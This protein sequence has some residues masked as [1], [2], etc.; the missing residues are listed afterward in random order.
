MGKRE[1]ILSA[2]EA[3]LEERGLYGLSMK[4]LAERAGIAAGTI[5]RYFENKDA[6]I[7]ELYL[8]I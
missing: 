3:L 4:V 2:A 5:Y 7:S 1:K 8:H 6:L